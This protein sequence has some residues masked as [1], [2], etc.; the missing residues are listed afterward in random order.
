MI[1]LWILALPLAAA[2]ISALPLGRGVA[3]AITLATCLAELA[4]TVAAAL[5]VVAAVPVV[6]IRDGSQSTD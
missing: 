4:L 6:A 3:P 1:L 5:R 2:L